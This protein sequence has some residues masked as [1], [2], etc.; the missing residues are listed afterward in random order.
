MSGKQYMT[1]KYEAS[2]E[3]YLIATGN[4]FFFYL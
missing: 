1:V 3:F 4:V 2:D